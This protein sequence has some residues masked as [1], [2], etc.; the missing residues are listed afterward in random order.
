M[1]SHLKHNVT[2]TTKTSETIIRF[3]LPDDDK[4][5]NVMDSVAKHSTL[6]ATG[7]GNFPSADNDT[8]L[9]DKSTEEIDTPV[10]AG[11]TTR[12][13]SQSKSP[14]PESAPPKKSCLKV[15]KPE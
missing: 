12:S 4:K 3:N 7:N 9:P 15:R 2:S 8:S 10:I 5:G 14:P 6:Q 13:K 11:V 1:I